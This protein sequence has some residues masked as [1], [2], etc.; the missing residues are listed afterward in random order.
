M[1][2]NIV[3]G[4]MHFY[5]QWQLHSIS[6]RDFKKKVRRFIIQSTGKDI[7]FLLFLQAFSSKDHAG[8]LGGAFYGWL[9][10]RYYL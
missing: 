6:E 10:W 7:L 1:G 2:L 5:K 8:H 9:F 4:L 3:L